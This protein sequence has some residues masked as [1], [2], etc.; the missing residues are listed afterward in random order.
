MITTITVTRKRQLVL[1]K[2]LCERAHI[3]PG[4]ELRVAKVGRGLY[5]SPLSPPTEK[6]LKEVIRAAGG[7]LTREPRDA[8]AKV[9][10]AIQAVRSEIK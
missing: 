8:A 3:A 1:P 2:E 4:S 5:F 6:E 10:A 7:P 9:K